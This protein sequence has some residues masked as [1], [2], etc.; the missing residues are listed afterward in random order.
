MRSTPAILI[1]VGA[2]CMFAI[3]TVEGAI[4]PALVAVTPHGDGTFTFTYEV[5]LA[6]DQAASPHGATPTG[7]VTPAGPGEPSA[8]FQDYFTIYDFYGLVGGSS[9]GPAGWTAGT[10]LIGPTPSTTAPADDP[11]VFNVFWVRTGEPSLGPAELGTFSVRSIFPLVWFDSYTSDATH[12]GAGT[13]VAS[14][15]TVDVPQ[16]TC[17]TCVPGPI[18]AAEPG[19]VLTLAGGLLALAVCRRRGS[20]R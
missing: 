3:P 17:F 9:A 15:G 12:Q 2:A 1:T 19:S 16:V 18:T 20:A 5:D 10:S 11:G 13:A 7:G 14:A 4:T 6:G 8:T